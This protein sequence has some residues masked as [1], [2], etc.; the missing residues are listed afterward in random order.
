MSALVLFSGPELNVTIL[1]VP[2]LDEKIWFLIRVRALR[3]PHIIIHPSLAAK[4]ASSQGRS[5]MET[6]STIWSILRWIKPQT[7]PRCHIAGGSDAQSRVDLR[8][9]RIT[10]Y[11]ECENLAT[12]SSRYG[13]NTLSL[14]RCHMLVSWSISKE[15]PRKLE[16]RNSL[17][18]GASFSSSRVNISPSRWL[19]IFKS[20]FTSQK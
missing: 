6:S 3:I 19:A 7:A 16:F 17:F 18:W 8:R 10:Y 9:I 14:D 13:W 1:V 20:R 11:E 5:E 12:L 4:S 2:L 15:T